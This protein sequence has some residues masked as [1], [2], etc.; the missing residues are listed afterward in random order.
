MKTWRH[1]D[2]ETWR[3][4]DME[5][6]TW[7]YGHG[8][9][10]M[11]TWTWRHQ[12][13]IWRHRH[14]DMDIETSTWRHGH[15]DIDMATWPTENEKRKPRQLSLIR[16]LFGHGE[17]GSLSFVR[18]LAKKQTEVFASKRTKRIKR[19]KGSKRICPSMKTSTWRNCK[20]SVYFL[21]FRE[22]K[23]PAKLK[24]LQNF[25]S[26][27]F[28]KQKICKVL[29]LFISG[30]RCWRNIISQKKKTWKICSNK[31][32]FSLVVISPNRIKYLWESRERI[33]WDKNTKE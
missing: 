10:D 22:I 27:R 30:R 18:L 25:V 9:T 16:L 23:E 3:H 21:S 5:T 4:G 26:Y 14:G 8:D 6:P 1:R 29:S 11:K 24:S 12:T 28:A 31:N 19:T 2:I 7:G 33:L 32:F 17:N 13:W 15:E 20:L